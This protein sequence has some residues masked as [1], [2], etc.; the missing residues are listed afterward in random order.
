MSSKRT[1]DDFNHVGDLM[2]EMISDCTGRPLGADGEE[3]MRDRQAAH[4]RM[5]QAEAAER[6]NPNRGPP[7]R[8]TTR[9]VLSYCDV[10][11]IASPHRNHAP[12][13][14][15]PIAEETAV[16]IDRTCVIKGRNATTGR[17]LDDGEWHDLGIRKPT[18]KELTVGE[19]PLVRLVLR[20]ITLN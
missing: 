20:F 7:V 5:R 18:N 9:A 14:A 17:I 4:R 3:N 15:N 8:A 16:D 2:L 12:A 6:R 10:N 19:M 11:T 13:Y 1:D